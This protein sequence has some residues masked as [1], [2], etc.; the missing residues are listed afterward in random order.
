MLRPEQVSD[1]IRRGVN[2]KISD[3]HNLYL[4]GFMMLM[5]A[6]PYAGR[7]SGC[8]SQIPFD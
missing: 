7:R 6:P 2:G 3:G 5:S 4:C 8:L 1:A